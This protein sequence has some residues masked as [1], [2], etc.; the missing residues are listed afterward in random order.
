M[1]RFI[2]TIMLITAI[3][4]SCYS[5]GGAA[6]R[7]F[8]PERVV[9]AEKRLLMDSISGLNEDQKLVIEVIY[10]DYAAALI[11]GRETADP[12]DRE[13]MRDTMLKI[14]NEKSDALKDILTED[15]YK[16][17]EEL[18]ARRRDRMRQRRQG[19]NE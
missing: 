14:R 3:A 15:Q 6:G 9:N 12:N 13:Q 5:Q 16:S 8:D 7:Q 4:T 10:Q 11:K 18:L 2:Y 1:K 19:Q 17:F